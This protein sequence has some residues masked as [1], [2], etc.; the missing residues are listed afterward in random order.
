MI[1][2]SE[3]VDVVNSTLNRNYCAGTEKKTCAKIITTASKEDPCKITS[4]AHGYSTGNKI[5]IQD[6]VGMTEINDRHFIVTY[7]DVDSFTIGENASG[8]PTEGSGGTC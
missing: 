8:Y 5:W 6:V 4:T 1:L 2:K 7:V 3:L